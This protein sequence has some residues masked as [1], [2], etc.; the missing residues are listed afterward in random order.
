LRDE[1][2]RN[3]QAA[4]RTSDAGWIAQHGSKLSGLYELREPLPPDMDRLVW[5]IGEKANLIAAGA[6]GR[7][8]K[9]EWAAQ[10]ARKHWQR[11]KTFMDLTTILIIVLIVLLLGGGGWYGRG[12]WY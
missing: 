1:K 7:T 12:R 8:K 6:M 5:A 11:R 4:R 2:V 3:T 9:P 10:S